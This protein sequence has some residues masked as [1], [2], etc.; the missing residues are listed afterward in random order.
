M[1]VQVKILRQIRPGD[2][3]FLETKQPRTEQQMAYITQQFK[4]MCPDVRVIVLQA[5][6]RVVGSPEPTIDNTTLD[7][8]QQK[9]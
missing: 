5:G 8:E 9:T 7:M 6:V 4:M 2:T 1:E 3:V